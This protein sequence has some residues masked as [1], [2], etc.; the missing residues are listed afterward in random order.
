MKGSITHLPLDHGSAVL[1][2][3]EAGEIKSNHDG[4][5]AVQ[6][7]ARW[8]AVLE[9]VIFAIGAGQRAQWTNGSFRNDVGELVHV[10]ADRG[11]SG[12]GKQLI[13]PDSNGIAFTF[14]GH[15]FTDKPLTIL[16]SWMQTKSTGVRLLRPKHA[17]FVSSPT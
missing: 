8:Y 13:N 7:L 3:V 17:R 9:L 1:I 16:D 2:Q 10:G 15:V 11:N 6:Q 5:K 14:V 12:Y 4:Q